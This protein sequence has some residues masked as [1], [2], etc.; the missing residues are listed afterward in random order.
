MVVKMALCELKPS[1]A[2]FR[3]KLASLLHNIKYTP[4]KSDP[5]VWMRPAI[6]SDGTEYYEYAL[7]YVDDVL[8][9]SCIPMK[10][11]EVIKFVFKLKRD[12]AEPPDM[13]LGASL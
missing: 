2:A 11:I 5:G 1:G 12:K 7:V 3:A 8:V 10:T 4:S 9:I 6:K 13:Y